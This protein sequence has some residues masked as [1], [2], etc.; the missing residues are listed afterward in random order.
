MTFIETRRVDR[1]LGFDI[2]D[3]FPSLPLH[4]CMDERFD[5]LGHAIV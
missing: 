1:F 5:V 4:E 3:L 2:P